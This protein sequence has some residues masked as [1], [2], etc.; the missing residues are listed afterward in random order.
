MEKREYSCPVCGNTNGYSPHG[1]QY[2]D[3]LKKLEIGLPYD[4]A[5]LLLD[6]HTE[7]TRTDRDTCTLIFTTA[8]IVCRL[9]DDGHSDQ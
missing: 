1:R 4:P 3:S 2:G 9:F 7:E 5:I 8:L 6:I